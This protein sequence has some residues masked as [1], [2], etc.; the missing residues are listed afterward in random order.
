M[1][2]NNDLPGVML[3]SAAQRLVYRYRVRPM[4]RAL[5]LTANCDGYRAALDLQANGVE[6]AAVVDLRAEGETSEVGAAVA[7]RRHRGAQ[8]PLRVRGDRH[9][10]SACSLPCVCEMGADGAARTDARRR[11]AC[12]GLVM[13]VGWAPA[14]ALLYQAG[15]TMRFDEA[16]QQFVPRAS[17]GRRLRRGPGQRRLRRGAEARGRPLRGAARRWLISGA[18]PR[19]AMRPL[20]R[21]APRPSHPL[22]DRRASAGQEL[23]RLRRGPAAQGFLQCGAGRLRQHRAAQALL[24]GRHGPVAGQAFE[25]ECDPHPRADPRRAVRRRGQHHGAA[26]LSPGAAGRARRAAASA[27]SA[28]RRC[29]RA[30]RRWAPCSRMAGNWLRPEYYPRAGEVTCRADPGRGARGARPRSV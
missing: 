12:D 25:H 29:M 16:L 28:A 21:E 11:I 22:S 26:V 27:R 15:A 10:T 30:T 6:V 1:F 9:R 8:G 18:Q 14:A 2:R 20:L 23:R 19:P 5:V 4:Q 7:A 17:A 3:A 13:S 24:H